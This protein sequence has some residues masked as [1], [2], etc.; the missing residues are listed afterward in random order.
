MPKLYKYVNMAK[1]MARLHIR[2]KALNDKF[3]QLS[4]CLLFLLK[5]VIDEVKL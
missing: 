4:A 5:S 3:Y 2:I 1:I